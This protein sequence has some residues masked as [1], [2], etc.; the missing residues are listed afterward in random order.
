[1]LQSSTD[2][3]ASPQA[4]DLCLGWHVTTAAGTTAACKQGKGCRCMEVAMCMMRSTGCGCGCGC[5]AMLAAAASSPV[6]SLSSCST[7][8]GSCHLLTASG[9]APL[10]L[11]H[12]QRAVNS[13]GQRTAI[14]PGCFKAQQ[15]IH[16]PQ[17]LLLGELKLQWALLQGSQV[18]FRPGTYS[19][20]SSSR[21]Q[22][23]THQWEAWPCV[24]PLAE[25]LGRHKKSSAARVDQP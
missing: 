5:S 17:Q 12:I 16:H 14:M 7:H 18:A 23:T 21:W 4:A 6:S 19:S 3:A 13:G 20:S 11:H 8:S 1:M 10:R 9:C 24:G 15:L 2:H 25:A 22:R